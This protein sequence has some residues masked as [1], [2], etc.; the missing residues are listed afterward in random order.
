MKKFLFLILVIMLCATVG[1]V[2]PRS[3]VLAANILPTPVVKAPPYQVVKPLEYTV[4]PLKFIAPSVNFGISAPWYAAAW[5]RG[6]WYY[7]S[8]EPYRWLMPAEA[9]KLKRGYCI[10]Y[11]NLLC[12]DLL[13]F[14][15]PAWVVVGVVPT[16][17]VTVQTGDH[18][19]VECQWGTHT[20]Y[21][22]C[23]HNYIVLPTGWQELYR[24][25]ESQFISKNG[26]Y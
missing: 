4:D 13:S 5:L 21:M 1:V 7:A 20:W 14:G 6:V 17:N 11:A 3:S 15:L 22:D 19:W 2:V 25:N 10:D 9:L 24:Y 26:Q 12:S 18:A 23:F 16:A 8:P